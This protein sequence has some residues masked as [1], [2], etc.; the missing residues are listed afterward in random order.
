MNFEEG[1]AAE[2]AQINIVGNKAFADEL[3][4]DTFEL[5]DSLPWWNFIGEKRY[6]KQQLS[7]DTETLES[8]YRDRGYLRFRVESVQVSMTPDRE[9]IYITINV[10]EGDKYKIS[11]TDVIGDLKGHDEL[12]G[13]IAKI[14][15]GTLYNAAQVTYIED[16]I[17]R[18][19][20]RYG[21]AYPE[22]RAIP[23]HDDEDKTV[24]IT[25]SINRKTRLRSPY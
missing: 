3:L 4:L 15:K 7:G 21:Y 24:K 9:G 22:V 12:V 14:E 18:F 13:K 17:S 25:F 2:I 8:F 23:E 1:D 11:E 16:M 19:Y 20:G 5:R 6:Q 10:S